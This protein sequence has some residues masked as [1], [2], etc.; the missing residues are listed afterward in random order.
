M[1]LVK[2]LAGNKKRVGWLL[3]APAFI[4]LFIMSIYPFAY[5]IVVSLHRW[6]IVPTIPRVFIGFQQY[7][8]LF[9][10]SG[11][12]QSLS[13]TL[14]YTIGVVIVE[15]VV[16]FL[17]ALLI[18]RTRIRWLRVAFLIPTVTTPVVVGL[19]WRFH[20]GFDLGAIN[21]FLSSIGI[22]KINWL[23]NALSALLSVML[24]DIWQWTPF[25]IIIFLAGLDS[26]PADPFEAAVVDGANGWQ[27]LKYVTLPLLLPVTAVILMFRTLD[28]FK[29]FDLI[30][31]VTM[32]G[33][34][35]ATEVLSYNIWHA[36]FF[37]N[38]IGYAS[39]L[40]VIAII[41]ATILMRIFITTLKKF[42]YGE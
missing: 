41:I 27:I 32:G 8:K 11:F 25:A 42:N 20:L 17:F 10:D 21:Y 19:I 26:L 38:R 9:S 34:A 31:M 39:A 40:S 16:G 22:G 15:V 18:S 30:Y 37:Q 12:Y 33:P 6:A 29:T 7:I 13:V 24:V 1:K 2:T 5:I 23:G 35:N 28:A 3:V 36:A 4:T 14:L